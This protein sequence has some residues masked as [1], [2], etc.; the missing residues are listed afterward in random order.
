MA[1][2]LPS[3]RAGRGGE[4]RRGGGTGEGE[5]GSAAWG[6]ERRPERA[7]AGGRAGEEI[8]T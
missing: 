8:A 3:E 4:A 7:R 5:W 6:C 2:C 1:E